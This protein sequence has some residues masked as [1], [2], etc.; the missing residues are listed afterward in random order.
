MTA[1]KASKQDINVQDK[2]PIMHGTQP[3]FQ[4]NSQSDAGV[5]NMYGEM[6]KLVLRN[7]HEI[8]N[9]RVNG[10]ICKVVMTQI[11]CRKTA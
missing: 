11:D 7:S 9:S 2:W 3:E 5:T 8:H 10:Q 1:R 4:T 6:I